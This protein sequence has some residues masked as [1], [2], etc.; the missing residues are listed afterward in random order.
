MSRRKEI[1][2]RPSKTACKMRDQAFFTL[3]FSNNRKW[4]KY[5]FVFQHIF[6]DL[7]AFFSI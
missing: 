4:A 2:F 3:I 1:E 7:N 6:A 5:F